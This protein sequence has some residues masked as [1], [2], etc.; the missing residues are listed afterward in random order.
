MYPN[1]FEL[2]FKNARFQCFSSFIEL[3]SPKISYLRKNNNSLNSYE[4]DLYINESETFPRLNKLL[5]GHLIPF[6]EKVKNS[7]EIIPI[8]LEL[9]NTNIINSQACSQITINN[10][11][12]LLKNKKKY[13][14]DYQNE[15]D[16]CIRYFV[17]L[18]SEIQYLD[19]DLI[20]E[21]LISIK[22]NCYKQRKY[23]PLIG[24]LTKTNSKYLSL[25][26]YLQ[27]ECFEEQDFDS[28]LNMLDD[29][30]LNTIKDNK[31][32]IEHIYKYMF[33]VTKS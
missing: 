17:Q 13:H 5:Q 12:F 27:I 29:I 10:V 9:G 16:F 32:A 6:F 11:I 22:D 2:I 25:I 15:I 19:Y 31:E 14:Y 21:I 26:K 8:L 20:K 1:D 4:I 23:I 33:N 28:F 30:G 3:I 7:D 24:K 18:Q